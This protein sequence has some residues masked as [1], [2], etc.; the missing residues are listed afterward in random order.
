VWGWGKEKKNS[1]GTWALREFGQK[2]KQL[3]ALMLEGNA[4]FKVP[5]NFQTKIIENMS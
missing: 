2:I 1:K 5:P 3:Q 4:P